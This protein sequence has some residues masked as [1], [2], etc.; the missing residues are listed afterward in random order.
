[1]SSEF[2]TFS[3]KKKEYRSLSNFW[4]KDIVIVLEDKYFVYSSGEHCFHG[5]KYY[6]LAKL[7]SDYDRQKQLH[8]YSIKFCKN[9]IPE[10]F[11]TPAH[12]KKAGGKNGLL[13][14][15]E[16]LKKWN[17]I[18]IDVQR[19]ICNYKYE[20]YEEVRNDLKKSGNKI[21]IHPAMRCSDKNIKKRLWE[22]RMIQNEDGSTEIIGGNM[23]GNIWM[24]LRDTIL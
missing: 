8:E 12:A 2:V 3:S 18:S 5:L 9:D 17:D 24:E 16:E 19:Q 6:E 20:N 7:C 4:E 15:D 11:T 23:L 1:M 10:C 22:G 13:L 21:L 14:T